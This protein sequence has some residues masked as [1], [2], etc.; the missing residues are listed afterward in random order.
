MHVVKKF[1]IDHVM[2]H[3][4]KLTNILQQ[5]KQLFEVSEIFIALVPQQFWKL[6]LELLYGNLQF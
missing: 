4:A 2:K 5:T 3:H 1:Y 6:L